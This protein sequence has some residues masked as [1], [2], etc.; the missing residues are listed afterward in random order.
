MSDVEELRPCPF[1]GGAASVI[2]DHETATAYV[3]CE[4]CDACGGR[5][6]TPANAIAAW[7]TRAPD[8]RIAELEAEVA[9]LKLS[10]RVAKAA[11]A[12]D[13]AINTRREH[14]TFNTLQEAIFKW[15]AALENKP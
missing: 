5:R 3:M 2:T 7:N 6:E 8:P 4:T 12:H 13:K 11:D 1:C 14:S 9:R 10:E 15:R